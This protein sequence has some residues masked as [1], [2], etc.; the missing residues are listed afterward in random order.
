MLDLYPVHLAWELINQKNK[1]IRNN[2]EN[3]LSAFPFIEYI[4]NNMRI[5]KNI[6]WSITW[7]NAAWFS[8]ERTETSENV[9][10]VTKLCL[11]SVNAFR[12]LQWPLIMA[13]RYDFPKNLHTWF[14]R[15]FIYYLNGT[16]IKPYF[17]LSLEGWRNLLNNLFHD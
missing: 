14:I 15:N 12:L 10:A 1:S 17:E 2:N 13:I 7:K 5:T 4:W 11:F 8:V 3:H 16:V 9:R 6:A